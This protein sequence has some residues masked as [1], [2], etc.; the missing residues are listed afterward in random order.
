MRLGIGMGA[1]CC[2]VLSGEGGGPEDPFSLLYFE[3]SAAGAA[4][5][6]P[7]VFEPYHGVEREY[8]VFANS[9]HSSNGAT[10][11]IYMGAALQTP[12]ASQY[13]IS[14]G[15]WTRSRNSF[16]AAARTVPEG[17]AL[18]CT[19]QLHLG[20]TAFVIGTG[21]TI[22]QSVMSP[23][24]SSQG[25]V[26]QSLIFPVAPAIG[27]KVLMAFCRGPLGLVADPGTLVLHAEPN[28]VAQF[29]EHAFYSAD[30]DG[31]K[32][33]WTITSNN[34]NYWLFSAGIVISPT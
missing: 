22:T 4:G 27:S 30:G 21:W 11:N 23:P 18:H 8:F 3:Q 29:Y 26:S 5:N 19:S 17:E 12:T 9:N 14:N 7:A 20:A 33:T 6:L 25:N 1:P 28:G 15:T 32:T 13:W 10:A 34:T 2:S 31:S 16:L 24:D